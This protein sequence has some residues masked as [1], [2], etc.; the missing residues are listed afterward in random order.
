MYIILDTETTGAEIEDRICQLAFLFCDDNLNIIEHHSQ[1]CQPPLPIKYEAMAVHHITPEMV[2]DAPPLHQTK[3]FRRLQELNTSNNT[4]VIHN[5]VFDLGMLK[6]ENFTNHMQLLD[7]LRCM[8]H[9]YPKNESN[10]LQILR[11]SLSLYQKE[12]AVAEA[13]HVNIQAHDALGDVIVLYLLLHYLLRSH[14][15]ESL[16]NTSAKPV[17]VSRLRFGK[18][19]GR[20][21]ESVIKEDYAYIT[22]LL[23]NHEAAKND[24]DLHYT[25]QL[26]LKKETTIPGYRFS[27]GKYKGLLIEEIIQKDKGYLHWALDNMTHL[28][29]H[30][31]EAIQK[32]LKENG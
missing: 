27:M 9:L 29:A 11:Y 16:I 12:T 5:A 19:R 13:L 8:R 17:F 15:K 1:L 30:F 28:D 18:Y 6:K 31:K 10:A 14:T 2:K 23:T 24:E 7:T 32:V 3:A 21:I 4:L 25:V 22:W 26:L 20:D